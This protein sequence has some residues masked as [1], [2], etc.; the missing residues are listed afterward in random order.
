M[1]TK[2]REAVF[3]VIFASR[4]SGE[5]DS[6]LKNALYKKENLSADDI[7][8]ADKVMTLVS[9]HESEFNEIID[10]LS[11]AFPQ[12]G[13]YPSD[14][15]ILYIA[16]AEIEYMDDIPFAVSV[17]EAANIASK[18]SSEKS[19]SFISGILSAVKKD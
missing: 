14:L 11:V 19:A 2:A 13:L 4:F 1:R 3:K 5:I 9:G 12:S 7:A 10:R 8:Y 6:N 15:S 18:Y 16:L 17:N